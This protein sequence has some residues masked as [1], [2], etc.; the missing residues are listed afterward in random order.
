ME[1]KKSNTGSILDATVPVPDKPAWE[2][3]VAAA[4]SLPLRQLAP[5]LSRAVFGCVDFWAVCAHVLWHGKRILSSFAL[6]FIG[7]L[8]PVSSSM[9][10]S[11]PLSAVFST[12]FAIRSLGPGCTSTLCAVASLLFLAHHSENNAMIFP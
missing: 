4:A 8:F 2:V 11:P 9:G 12:P 6:V 3:T 5:E 1:K 7:R 10:A